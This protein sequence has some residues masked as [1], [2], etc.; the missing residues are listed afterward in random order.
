MVSADAPEMIG[1]GENDFFT[2]WIRW[3]MAIAFRVGG[4]Y[5]VG[6]YP[7][8]RALEKHFV[9]K[10]ISCY[11]YKVL[12]GFCFFIIFDEISHVILPWSGIRVAFVGDLP[13]DVVQI[14]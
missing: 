7:V 8:G 14:I 3:V 13:H 5:F 9:L 4:A 6:A 10:I 2:F 11:P 1:V 12:F